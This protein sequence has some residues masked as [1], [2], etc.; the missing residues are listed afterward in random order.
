MRTIDMRKWN[1]TVHGLR[2]VRTVMPPTT[3][4]AATPASTASARRC[5]RGRDGHRVRTTQSEARASRPTTPVSVRFPNSTR[6]W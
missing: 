4:W 5:S 2:P 3:A 1:I 6:S